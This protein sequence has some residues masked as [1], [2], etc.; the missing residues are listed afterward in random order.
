MKLKFL[1]SEKTTSWLAGFETAILRLKP[2]YRS[3]S[4]INWFFRI[5]PANCGMGP[6]H[7]VLAFR[8]VESYPSHADR[9]IRD[10]KK[11]LLSQNTHLHQT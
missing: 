10:L 2:D 11:Q 7:R 1:I 8:H 5:D 3:R 6:A 9:E 4:K